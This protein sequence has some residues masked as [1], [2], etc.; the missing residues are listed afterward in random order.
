MKIFRLE[1]AGQEVERDW[2]EILR[3]EV[4]FFEYGPPGI[5]KNWKILLI[6]YRFDRGFS[7]TSTQGFVET[8]KG[9]YIN[10][11]RGWR[12]AFQDD[13]L[14]HIGF[15]QF[16]IGCR[17]IGY[18]GNIKSL[19]NLLVSQPDPSMGVNNTGTVAVAAQRQVSNKN[20][21]SS[22]LA[23]QNKRQ[24]I[25]YFDVDPT[26]VRKLHSFAC[27][28]EE[29]G[30]EEGGLDMAFS[31]VTFSTVTWICDARMGKAKEGSLRLSHY[32]FG[33]DFSSV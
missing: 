5:G 12:V 2:F 28:V 32:K 31:N 13:V 16:L 15:Q 18:T 10:A 9:K 30:K 20:A 29:T 1:G 14:E 7:T 19:W 17:R 23:L 27:M 11:V 26:G 3:Q 25:S 24:T 22:Q 8:L 6:L 4:F 33:T 21:T